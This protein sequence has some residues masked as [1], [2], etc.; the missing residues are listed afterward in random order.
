M[1]LFIS[2]AKKVRRTFTIDGLRPILLRALRL[3]TKARTDGFNHGELKKVY[4]LLED[5]TEK[6]ILFGTGDCAPYNYGSAQQ[7]ERISKLADWCA[8]KYEGDFIEIGSYIGET[9]KELTKLARKYHRRVIV[10]D[11]WET[12]TQNC[13]G[14]EY[15]KFIENT[16]PYRDVLDII[17]DSS[18]NKKTVNM[19][20]SRKLCFAF[21]DGL[22][23]Y[24]ACLSDILTVN[25]TSGVIA[26]D[27]ILSSNNLLLAFERGAY[28]TSRIPMHHKLCREGYLS[29]LK[30]AEL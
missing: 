10:V 24:P 9:T 30:K 23:T 6:E 7:I 22:H 1:K 16:K 11:P 13:K 20:K 26:V 19:I 8:E 21:I 14:W 15:D 28:L 29:P 2:I 4:K 12:G 3:T 25:H 17:R 27:D 18:F 5:T